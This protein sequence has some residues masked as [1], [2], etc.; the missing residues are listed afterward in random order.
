M[1]SNRKLTAW[2]A[3]GA[4]VALAVVSAGCDYVVPPIQGAA[5][6]VI[7]DSGWAGIVN[8]VSDSGGTL[9]VDLSIVNKTKQWSAMDVGDS[10]AKI[11]DSNGTSHDCGT[12][13][14]G[15]A[16]FVNNGG[17]Y[18]AP[19]FVMKGY[20]GGTEASPE[21]QPLYVECAGIAKGGGQKLSISYKYITGDFNYFVATK[22]LFKTMELNLDEVA[23]DTKYPVA[24]TL[25][26]LPVA[27]VGDAL[28]A[29]N[30]CTVTLVEA[31]RT[32]EGLEFDWASTNPTEYPAYVHIGIPPLIGSDGILYG[33]YQ[34]PHL[35]TVP[36]TKAGGEAKWS[37][38]QAV[39]KEVTGLYIML[40]LETKQAKYFTD[41]VV[42]VTGL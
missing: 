1:R 20:T 14:V 16:V 25:D 38:K 22:P 28:T 13:V 31:R 21:T 15:T 12:V 26:N 23:T 39:P 6:A 8:N 36:I 37:T 41:Y 40:P 17:W 29:I 2:T 27:K 19:G 18:L 9:R 42:D 5:T 11:V 34:T 4:V 10:K 35:A 3:M 33:F 30:A 24:E 7:E 32:A